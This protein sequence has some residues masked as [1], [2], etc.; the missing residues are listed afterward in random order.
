MNP[1]FDEALQS[2]INAIRDGQETI[3][4]AVTHYPEFRE[5]LLSEL[6]IVI[7][8]LDHREGL[9]PRPGF[10]AASRKRLVQRIQT[11]KP[12]SELTWRERFAQALD[13]QRI[14]PVAF[15]AVLLLALVVTGTIVSASQKALPGDSLYAIKRT[16][17]QMAIVATLDQG[18]EAALQIQLVENRLSE[19]KALLVERRYQDVAQ[20]V[21]DKAPPRQETVEEYAVTPVR[22]AHKNQEKE[23]LLN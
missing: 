5:E 23:S 13:V 21:E 10:V 12:Q 6:R 22:T 14:A 17:E 3:D 20:V 8:L 15:V 18:N 19:V 11:E 9:E 4:S 1:N 2:C 7:W 16:L